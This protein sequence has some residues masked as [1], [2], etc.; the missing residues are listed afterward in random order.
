MPASVGI[1]PHVIAPHPAGTRQPSAAPTSCD[2]DAPT[3]PCT[4][5]QAPGAPGSTL[6]RAGEGRPAAAPGPSGDEPTEPRM[7][8]AAAAEYFAAM[9]PRYRKAE[10]RRLKTLLLDEMCKVTRRT[11]KHIIAV[12]NA[13]RPPD[14]R[15]RTGRPRKHSQA[16]VAAVLWFRKHSGHLNAP[17]LHA[18]L[19][20]LVADA[21]E[22][23]LLV[24]DPGVKEEVLE[25][26]PA[27]IGRR[28]REDRE[29][30]PQHYPPQ[31]RRR[32]P[33]STLQAMIPIRISSEW[34]AEP[35]GAIQA[36][37]V[38]HSGSSARGGH[39]YT[40]MMVDVCTHWVVMV[41]LP[42]KDQSSVVGGLDQGRRAFPFPVRSLHSDNGSEIINWETRR[43]CER[44]GIEWTR[45]RPYRSNDQAVA[46]QR[47]ATGVRRVTGR[48][49]YSG[50]EA[51]A[52]L[53]KLLS[54]RA[55]YMNFFEPTTRRVV[56]TVA[57]ENGV[58]ELRV[59]DTPNTPHRR[60]LASG[61]LDAETERRLE[62]TRRAYSRFKLK[63]EIDELQAQ[64]YELREPDLGI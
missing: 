27:T 7:S 41:A 53:S 19:P 10:R 22:E 9:R 39:L 16:A 5:V 24:L 14:P 37:L 13:H 17:A 36:D 42:G 64:L 34:A 15:P 61:L 54:K 51:L 55:L 59:P 2:G 25:M 47:N 8:R 3:P 56:K 33:P 32:S 20:Y 57:S 38:F 40:L 11:R 26:P 29:R 23:G 28:I 49:R 63:T 35:P 52:V 12:M 21:E 46:E 44:H 43:W 60:F 45:G 18:E 62:R 48:D 4:K 31:P 50:P 58:R 6:Q 1:V 30:S